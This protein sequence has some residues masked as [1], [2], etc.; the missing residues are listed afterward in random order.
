[1]STRFPSR[2][3]ITT[4]SPPSAA[5]RTFGKFLSNSLRLVCMAICLSNNACRFSI[6]RAVGL[7]RL[8]SCQSP[9][10]VG[11]PARQGRQALLT[12][13]FRTRTRHP[14]FDLGGRS[15]ALSVCKTPCAKNALKRQCM[16]PA[17]LTTT[18]RSPRLQRVQFRWMAHVCVGCRARNPG[19]FPRRL[20]CWGS[21]IAMVGRCYLPKWI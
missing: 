13:F 7:C 12:D 8:A 15:T 6:Y 14:L 4:R 2:V 16:Q 18:G 5:C 1:M 9:W 3:R 21:D 20:A 10:P 17:V 19:G 11:L